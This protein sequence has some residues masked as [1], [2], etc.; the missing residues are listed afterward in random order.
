M[1]I[2]F[3]MTAVG[4]TFC[5]FLGTISVS[6]FL[7]ELRLMRAAAMAG[8]FNDRHTVARPHRLRYLPCHLSDQ[9]VKGDGPVGLASCF[10]GSFPT[11]AWR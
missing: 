9:R 6:H 5:S 3:G 4:V 10:S 2:M 1:T 11:L 8:Q 7:Y